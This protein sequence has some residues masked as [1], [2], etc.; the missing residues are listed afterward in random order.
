[1]ISHLRGTATKSTPGE[2]VIDV[3]GVGYG[4]MLP[5]QDWD[6]IKDGSGVFLHVFTYVREDRFELYGFLEHGTRTLFEHLIA[7]S[8]IGP[9]MGLELCSVPRS[10]MSKAI[11]EKDPRLLQSV[12]GVGKKSAEKLLLELSSL[13]ERAP[14]IFLGDMRTPGAQFD[15]DTIAALSQLGFATQ[16]IL[17]VLESLPAD[18]TTTEE[19]VA[20]AL[21]TL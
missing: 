11:H 5:M 12:K 2:A 19:R 3:A 10:L 20:A 17:R 9:R 1:M 16:D 8:G 21:R 18:L 7:L 4:V 14:E 13:A 15:Q 6:V